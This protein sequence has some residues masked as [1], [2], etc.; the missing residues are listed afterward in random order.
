MQIGLEDRQRDVDGGAVDER[1]ARP[2]D[3]RNQRPAAVH[4]LQRLHRAIA[5]LMPPSSWIIEHR[6]GCTSGMVLI[7]SVAP[8]AN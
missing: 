2:D 5:T 3:G 7:M 4:A 1:E 6:L 8:L